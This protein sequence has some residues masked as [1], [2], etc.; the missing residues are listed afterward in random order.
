MAVATQVKNPIV[1]NWQR[2]KS[3]DVDMA[4][5]LT[6]SFDWRSKGSADVQWL[7][8]NFVGNFDSYE[9]V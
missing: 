4:G 8:G 2:C 9:T 5:S 7:V 6:L 1:E 3:Y